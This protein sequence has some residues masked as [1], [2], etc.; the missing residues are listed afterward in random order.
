MGASILDDPTITGSTSG[1]AVVVNWQF[2]VSRQAGGSTQIPSSVL[3]SEHKRGGKR[4]GGERNPQPAQPTYRAY[5]EEV[6]Q[7]IMEAKHFV[8]AQPS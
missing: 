1:E 5:S 2:L 4:N 6:L 7:E 8:G 3:D